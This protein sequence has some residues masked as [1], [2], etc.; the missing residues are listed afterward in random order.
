MNELQMR[1][2]FCIAYAVFVTFMY[3][4]F[5]VPLNLAEDTCYTGKP[6]HLSICRKQ[7]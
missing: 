4:F 7:L 6:F 1:S 5:C 3:T 2:I